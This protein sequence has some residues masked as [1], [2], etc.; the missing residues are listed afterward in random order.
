ML[1]DYVTDL[2]NIP[3]IDRTIAIDVQKLGDFPN[4]AA[5]FCHRRNRAVFPE[6]LTGEDEIINIDAELDLDGPIDLPPPPPPSDDE[7][8]D[9]FVVVEQMPEIQGGMAAIS[10]K[11]EYPE[12][13]RRAGIEG[14]VIVQ[15][16]VNENGQVENPRVVR[17][18][19]GG[20]DQEALRVI[21]EVKFKPGMQRGRPVRVQFSLPI[22]FRLSN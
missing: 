17:G 16:I 10:S 15:F 18:I 8:E 22:V 13:A 7:E 4:L 2:H 12:M 21:R 20:C 9:F 11:I 1:K 14:R 19:G 3:W 6:V 5:S